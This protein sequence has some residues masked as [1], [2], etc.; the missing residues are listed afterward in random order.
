MIDTIFFRTERQDATIYFSRELGPGAEQA[1]AAMPGVLAVE[2]LRSVPVVLHHGH[3]SRRLTVSGYPPKSDLARLLDVRLDAVRPPREGLVVSQRVADLLHL[4]AGERV[5]MELV[6]RDGRMVEVPVTEIIQSF[7]GLTVAMRQDALDRLIA[8]GPR[9]SGARVRLDGDRLQAFYE[10]VKS[11]PE[12][13][14][15][16][17]LKLSR[18]RFR[19]TID[20]NISIMTTVYIALAVIITFGVV[21]NFAR[22]QLSER[23]RELASLRVLGFTRGEVASVLTIE[24]AVIVLAAQ[25]IGWGLGYLFSWSVTQ[26]FESDLFRVPLVVSSTTFATASLVVLFAAVVSGLL[27]RRRID[28]LDLVRVLKSRE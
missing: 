3:R 18:K 11:T 27:V 24:L 4:R 20:Q 21:Y 1:V 5:R 7:I 12:A 16:A 26:G 23:A 14:S 9:L 17:L 2:P 22:I 28:R 25:P 15:V 6:E 13:A 10:A 19:E 8:D